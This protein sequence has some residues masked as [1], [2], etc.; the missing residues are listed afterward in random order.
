MISATVTNAGSCTFTSNRPLAGLATAVP[1]SNGTVTDVVLV[2]ANTGR[3][4]VKFKLTLVVTGSSKVKV[5]ISLIESATAPVPAP[6]NII[7]SDATGFT[8]GSAGTF[9]V[10]ATGYPAPSF[11]ES[12]ALPPGVTFSSG[13][14]LSG[15]P[16]SS[17]AGT[18]P[19]M[20]TAANGVGSVATQSFELTVSP[21]PSVKS[22]VAEGGGYCA[23]LSSGGVDCWGENEYGELGNGG[24]PAGYGPYPTAVVGLDGTSTLS[25]VASLASDYTGFCAVLFSGG[26]D[27]WGYNYSGQLGNGRPGKSSCTC[28]SIP[29]AV[30]GVGGIGALAGVDHLVGSESAGGYCAVL[31]SGGVDCW[32]N[33]TTGGLGNG[34]S[35]IAVFPTAVVGVGGIGTL[36]GV[37]TLSSDGN[38]Y[39]ALLTSKGVDCWGYDRNGQL[40]NG[41]NTY[42]SLVP[43]EVV[44]EGGTGTLTGVATLRSGDGLGSFCAVLTSG[45]VDC[46]GDN[47]SGQLGNGTT[48]DTLV[49]TAVVGVGGIGP[50]SGVADVASDG[51]FGNCAS[52]VS[53]GVDC[54]G[55]NA[56]GQ[57]GDGTTANSLVPTEVV[58]LSGTGT[59]SGVATVESGDGFGTYCAVI[60]SGGV[61]C[62][63]SNARDQL[64]NGTTG[65]IDVPTEVV[66]EGGIGTV[67]GIG[68][69][70]PG[71]GLGGFCAVPTTGGI[72]CW[73]ANSTG[74]LGNGTAVNSDVPTAVHGVGGTGVL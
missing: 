53:G 4:P 20:I 60:T 41:T 50:L 28:S 5:K 48:A 42:R 37:A 31:T 14:L 1:C 51:Q 33:G 30:A 29:T 61:D 2:P 35:G 72:D 70:V 16:L 71:L 44:G 57:L 36:S 63:G 24:P 38:G 27:C 47:F 23:L 52:L 55:S 9:D 73:G 32:G 59:L 18:Y 39:C 67:S 19:L 62:W 34:G 3:K 40:G 56:A 13:G 7:S 66:G 25:G 26:V 22:V 12:G 58:D 74:Q 8:E 15:T 45:G 6:P 11:T 46:W 17:A 68:S 54:W 10:V 21:S 64:G 69:L 43:T 65:N 49:P